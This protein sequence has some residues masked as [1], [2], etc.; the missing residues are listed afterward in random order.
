MTHLI[1]SLNTNGKPNG[2]GPRGGTPLP[3]AACQKLMIC[4][5]SS[6]PIHTHK[7]GIR[8]WTLLKKRLYYVKAVQYANFNR[9]LCSITHI[10]VF[11]E[12]MNTAVPMVDNIVQYLLFVQNYLSPLVV[13]YKRQ[14]VESNFFFYFFFF[15][16]SVWS[17]EYTCK[18]I[19]RTRMATGH[20]GRRR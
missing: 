3:C 11:W 14:V 4:L 6:C 7:V 5:R 1:C 9:Y 2:W 19:P 12:N 8:T 10:D 20:S 15:L 17:F 18:T 13:I 16:K